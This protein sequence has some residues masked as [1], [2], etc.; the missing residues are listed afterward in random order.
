MEADTSNLRPIT[1]FHHVGLMIWYDSSFS[2]LG[3][4]RLI[5]VSMGVLSLIYAND[6][7]SFMAPLIPPR[8]ESEE[9]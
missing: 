7:V 1:S 8:L 4:D 6:I 9:L 5:A 2:Y 3:F